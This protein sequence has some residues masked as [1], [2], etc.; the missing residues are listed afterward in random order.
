MI[1]SKI[2]YPILEPLAKRHY[3]NASL[4]PQAV[5]TTGRKTTSLPTCV[6]PL[7]TGQSLL[8]FLG[9]RI[10]AP[11]KMTTVVDNDNGGID[12]DATGYTSFGRGPLQRA[13]AVGPGWL[14]AAGELA[15]TAED[16]ARW[17]I[18]IITQSLMSPGAY[19]AL[20]Q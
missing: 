11:L 5:A 4:T 8:Q 19:H 20:E 12:N 16:L 13:P 10:F 6:K 17:D 2:T 1:R 3:V 18:S 14:F 15:M 7:V 9:E